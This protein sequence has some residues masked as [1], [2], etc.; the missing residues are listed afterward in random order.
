MMVPLCH[1]NDLVASSHS[2]YVFRKFC[3]AFFLFVLQ[4]SALTLNS[5]ESFECIA[6]H[7]IAGN[8][9]YS[10]TGMHEQHAFYHAG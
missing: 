9:L 8:R 3:L 5:S 7:S 6:T 10:I 1:S 2:C 4:E